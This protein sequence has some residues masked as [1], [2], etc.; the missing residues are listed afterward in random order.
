MKNIFLLASV[1]ICQIAF[2]QGIKVLSNEEVSIL[3]SDGYFNPV[4][5]PTGDFMLVTSADLQ[6]LQKYDFA[7]KKLTPITSGASAGF[8]AQITS[9]GSAVVY[10]TTEYKDRL[11][12]ASLKSLNLKTGEETVLIEQTRNL[13]GVVVKDGTVFAVD[14]GALKSQ[15][16][17]GKSLAATPPVS[18]IKNS[19]LYVT[20]GNSTR[21]VCPLGEDK[22]YLWNSVSPDGT[23]LLFYVIEHGKAYV[24]NIDGSNPVSLGTLRAAKWM[25]NDW[26]VGMVDYDDGHVITSSK[27]VAA[28]AN[29]KVRTDLTD[30][31]VIAT[32]P[33][34][35]ADASKILYNT[36]DGKVYLMNIEISK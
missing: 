30:S 9:D 1:L 19:Q 31:S 22:G 23:K 18:S 13:E 26:V 20:K 14:N 35:A 21:L 5:S 2:S 17:A 34:P 33:T 11:R 6:G 28:T 36:G 12:Y 29:G 25:G 27:I 15:K 8:D 3:N 16:V 32:Y 7:T 4:L 24:S 10:R